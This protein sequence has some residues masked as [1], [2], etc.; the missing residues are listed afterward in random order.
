MNELLRVKEFKSD[1]EEDIVKTA[2]QLFKE[3][4]FIRIGVDRIVKDS[5]IAKSTFYFYFSSKDELLLECLNYE[6]LLHQHMVQDL[7]LEH[8]KSGSN[9]V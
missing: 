7:I 8:E 6:I 9:V 3:V 4:S 1:K 5:N 2:Y